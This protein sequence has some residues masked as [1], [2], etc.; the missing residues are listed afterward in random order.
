MLRPDHHAHL[1][2]M[3]CIMTVIGFAVSLSGCASLKADNG[4]PV[5][6]TANITPSTFCRQMT[7][8]DGAGEKQ[9]RLSYEPADTPRTANEIE[10]VC[11]RWEASC[12]P[13]RKTS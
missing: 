2:F 10:Q 6:R 3:L 13:K 5:G 12:K 8:I 7:V 4:P 9:C 11:A 1:L